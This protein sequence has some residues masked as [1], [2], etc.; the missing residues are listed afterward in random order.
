LA[1]RIVISGVRPWDGSYEIDLDE[2]PLTI[3]EWGWL[4]RYAGYLPARFDPD[5]WSDP[6]LI[7]VLAI[8]ALWRSGTIQPGDV[9]D[10]W[11]RLEDAPHGSTIRLEFG[12]AIAAEDDAGPPAVSSNASGSTSGDSST[13]ASVSSDAHR[14]RTGSPASDTLPSVPLTSAS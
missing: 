10:V 6:E 4:K 12:E 2:Q 13:T 8:V 5:S 14:S 1:D 11:D 9:G 7:G 3:R